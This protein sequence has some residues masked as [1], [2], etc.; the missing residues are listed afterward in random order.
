M[1]MKS[2]KI[3][4]SIFICVCTVSSIP[5]TSHRP[6]WAMHPLCEGDKAQRW[7]QWVE[8]RGHQGVGVVDIVGK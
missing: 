7:L 2:D 5:R 6:S 3:F 1:Q 4:H 8:Q